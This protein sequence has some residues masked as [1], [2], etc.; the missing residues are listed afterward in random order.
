MGRERGLDA[1]G[2]DPPGAV[3]RCSVVDQYI[4]TVVAP[5]DLSCQ[6][7]HLAQARQVSDEQLDTAWRPSG[8]DLCGH[9]GTAPAVTGHHQHPRTRLG[10]PPRRLAADAAGHA[11]DEADAAGQVIDLLSSHEQSSLKVGRG[12]VSLSTCIMFIM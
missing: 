9:L 2:G 7:P 5:A 6:R 11:G 4:E 10:Q 12:S 1:L 3:H 8:L